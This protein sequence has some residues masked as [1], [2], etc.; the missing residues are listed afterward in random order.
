MDKIIVVLGFCFS[1]L[2][3][4]VSTASAQV[5]I[6]VDP[7]VVDEC[8][9]QSIIFPSPGLPFDL[10]FTDNKTLTL[11]PGTL[12][13]VLQGS[14]VIF[15]GAL[16]DAV[17][18]EISG[19]DYSGLAEGGAT[20]VPLSQSTTWHGMRFVSDFPLGP[21]GLVFTSCP[22]VGQSDVSGNQKP[23]ANA[24]TDVAGT[25]GVD[26]LFDGSASSDP[27]G[28]IASY[29]WDFG[30]GVNGTGATPSHAYAVAGTYNVTLMVTDNG[31]L[32]DS[33]TVSATIGAAGT[34]PT[35]DAGGP[36]TGTVGVRMPVDGSNSVDTDGTIVR[37][38]WDFDDGNSDNSDR[39]TSGNTYMASGTY[40]I[41]L[42]VTDD[43]GERG[44]DTATA[45]IGQGNQSPI[46]DAGPPVVGASG[47]PVSFD[48]SASS[49]PDGDVLRY[50]WDFGDGGSLD[51]GGPT[52]SHI[53]GAQGDYTATVVVTDGNNG[54]DGDYTI[55]S[56]DAADPMGITR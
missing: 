44:T 15:N 41:T 54:S 38:S 52:P 49:D 3:F 16:L 29:A 26:V 31:E 1:L 36:Y 45:T 27:D 20:Q 35:A 43:N 9:D 50:D 22:V 39:P 18:N 7:G 33:D 53:Y 51:D 40:T 21:A 19:T 23:I 25:V 14:N 55:A 47:I 37:Y 2:I 42:T 4:C 12:A 46:A 13:F 8:V 34:P 30:D 6:P 32:S 56:I 11:G 24:G 17:G 5:A 28:D 48:A 10:V